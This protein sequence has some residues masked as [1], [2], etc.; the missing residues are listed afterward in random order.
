M[1]IE[2]RFGKEFE[3]TI[4]VMA[5]SDMVLWY[6]PGEEQ[7]ETLSI[8]S[9]WVSD[10]EGYEYDSGTTNN[11]LGRFLTGFFGNEWP[12]DEWFPVGK[13]LGLNVFINL[14]GDR[15]ATLFP[16]A[17]GSIATGRFKDVHV[18]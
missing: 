18:K 3:D 5:K 10:G 13:H 2:D 7:D 6:T 4:Q 1:N 16:V 8:G 15:A 12:N 17:D 14:D 11:A 9:W